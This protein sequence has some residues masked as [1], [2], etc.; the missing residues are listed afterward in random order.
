[1][2]TTDTEHAKIDRTGWAA[3]PWDGEPD[4]VEWRSAA[5]FP[6]LLRRVGGHGAWCGYV[7]VPP[8]HPYHGV[9]FNRVPE[10]ADVHGGLTYSDKCGGDIC[11]VPAPGE[12]DDVWWLGFDASHGFDRR[13]G[14]EAQ[15]NSDGYAAWVWYG[16]S[17][18][19]YRTVDYMRAECERLAATLAEVSP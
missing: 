13:P 16:S 5:G 8:G 11:H 1:M 4:R 12:S 14:M 18:A 9:D 17:S 7:A 6:C 19:V 10:A 3:G 2:A 15:L